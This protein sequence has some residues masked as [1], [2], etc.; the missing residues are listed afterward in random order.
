M[1]TQRLQRALAVSAL[2][3]LQ[4]LGYGAGIYVTD[5]TV[6]ASAGR[7]R[8]LVIDFADIVDHAAPAEDAAG[9]PDKER[10]Q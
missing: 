1:Q 7:V 4:A 2:Q 10:T 9:A 5:I 3:L 8:R 6:K